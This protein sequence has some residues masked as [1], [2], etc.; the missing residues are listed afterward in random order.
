MLREILSQAVNGSPA[1][2]E[3]FDRVCRL[4]TEV[5]SP[6]FEFAV[7]VTMACH[8]STAQRVSR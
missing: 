3:A 6:L 1:T 2:A 5:S 7:K 4:A 8:M